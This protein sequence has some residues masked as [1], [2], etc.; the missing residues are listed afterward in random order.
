MK[1]SGIAA[2]AIS[3]EYHAGLKFYKIRMYRHTSVTKIWTHVPRLA[4]DIRNYGTPV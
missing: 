2:S 4:F 3:H 1:D